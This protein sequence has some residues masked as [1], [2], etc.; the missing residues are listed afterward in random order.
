MTGIQNTPAVPADLKSK[1]KVELAGGVP[2]VAD[3]DLKT[4]LSKAGVPTQAAKAV[5]DENT[6]ARLDGLT[7]LSVMALIA[8]IALLVG[9]R[10]PTE[11]PAAAPDT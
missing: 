5:V 10:L 3:S 7:A 11:Q 9:L 8:L 2:F 6:T 4:A 1:A